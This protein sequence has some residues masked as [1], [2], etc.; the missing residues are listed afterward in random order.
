[1]CKVLGEIR[2]R[3]AETLQLLLQDMECLKKTM[4]DIKIVPTAA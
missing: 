2:K 4:R 3:N 1:M